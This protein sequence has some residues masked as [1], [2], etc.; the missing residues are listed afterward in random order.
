MDYAASAASAAATSSGIGGI[1]RVACLDGG[2]LNSS[3]QDGYGPSA[4]NVRGAPPSSGVALHPL[5]LQQKK[6]LHELERQQLERV[7]A[8][9]GAHAALRLKTEREMCAT[10][11][12]LPGLSSSLW[13]L[14][15]VMALDDQIITED[16]LGRD[17]PETEGGPMLTVHDSIERAMGI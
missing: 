17:K 11:Q 3:L 12:R 1:R 6:Y 10:T 2:L 14:Q 7:T 15:T 5:E 4:A 9:F 8:A 13:G 16:Y